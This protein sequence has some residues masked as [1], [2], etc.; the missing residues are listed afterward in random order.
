MNFPEDC[1]EDT[2]DAYDNLLKFEYSLASTLAFNEWLD[3]VR[4][5]FCNGVNS[6]LLWLGDEHE[7]SLRKTIRNK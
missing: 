1:N 4:F 5:N 2:A 6:K 3:A 7:S